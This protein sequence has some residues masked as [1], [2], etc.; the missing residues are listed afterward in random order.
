MQ[1][2]LDTDT[3]IQVLRGQANAVQR[4]T[5]LTPGDCGISTI[6]AYELYTGAEKCSNPASEKPKVER[7]LATVISIPFTD[8]AA[9]QA[10]ILRAELERL[11]TPIGPYD[12]L[13]AA[14]ATQLNLTLVTSNTAEFSRVSGLKLEDWRT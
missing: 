1:Y 6:S 9:K 11:G 2:L 4:L 3:C 13:I 5:A 12:T 10:A 8:D 14:Q 7:L